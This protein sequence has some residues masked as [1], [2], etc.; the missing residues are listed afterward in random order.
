MPSTARAADDASPTGSA[1]QP[2][3]YALE[4]S[5]AI[6]GALVQWLRDNLGLIANSQ[7]DRDAGAHRG[8]Q[9]RRLLR[10]GV[11]RPV[12]RRIGS[13]DARGVIVRADAL[14]ESRP[15]RARGARGDGVSD[16]RGARGDGEDSGDSDQASCASTAAWS[17]NELLMQFQADI[18]ACRWCARGH[19]DDGARRRVCRRARDR[20]LVDRRRTSATIG[21]SAIAGIRR[22]AKP[23]APSSRRRGIRR[24]P[25]R[26]GG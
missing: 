11:L 8:R 18:S 6:A 22:W 20:L 13:D 23:G 12:T 25:D 19:R 3:V 2:A 1:T 4:G 5:I 26:S 7:R 9:R 17:S 21:P 14:R 24:S 15:H 10:A 16:A